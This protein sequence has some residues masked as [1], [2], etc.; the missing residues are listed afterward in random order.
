M[1]SRTMGRSV[2][3]NQHSFSEGWNDGWAGREAA[4]PDWGDYMRG[5]QKG[6]AGLERS[7]IKEQ[8]LL[9]AGNFSNSVQ[10]SIQ[11]PTVQISTTIP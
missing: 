9:L 5:W 8:E 3:G 4:F 7:Q 2:V 10:N 11:S 6:H 1:S